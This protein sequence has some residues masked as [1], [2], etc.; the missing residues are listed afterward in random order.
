MADRLT[1]IVACTDPA[2]KTSAVQ[3]VAIAQA[4][5]SG[6]RVIFYDFTRDGLMTDAR[7]NF[8]AGEGEAER[9]DR[10]LDPVSIEKLGY[11]DLALTVQRARSEGVDA[12]GWLPNETGGKGLAAYAEREQADLVL[13][14]AGSEETARYVEDLRKAGDDGAVAVTSNIQL[15]DDD[16]TLV[17]LR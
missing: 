8:W 2:G 7:P 11:H 3:A 1:C 13:L 10:P 9:Y 4:R 15:V 16:Q 14:P 6:A 5:E 12:F 17:P